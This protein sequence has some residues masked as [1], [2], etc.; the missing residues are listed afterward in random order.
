MH[1]GGQVPPTS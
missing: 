1:P